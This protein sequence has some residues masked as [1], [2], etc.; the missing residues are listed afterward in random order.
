MNDNNSFP[1]NDQNFPPDIPSGDSS[2]PPP[3]NDIPPTGDLEQ[4]ARQL[5][6]N[7]NKGGKSKWFVIAAVVLLLLAIPV[8]ILLTQRAGVGEIREKAQET[9]DQDAFQPAPLAERRINVV[10]V[11]AAK[12]DDSLTL[13]DKGVQTTIKFIPEYTKIYRLPSPDEISPSEIPLN[14]YVNGSVLITPK[15]RSSSG[16]EVLVGEILHLPANL[17]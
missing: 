15:D 8:G 7:E 4:Q 14:T 11:L 5:L 16:K 2:T 3:P 10:G 9:T 17:K 6:G 13:E 1:K 12:T